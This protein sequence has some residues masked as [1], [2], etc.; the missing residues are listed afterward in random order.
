MRQLIEQVRA[1]FESNFTVAGLKL[2]IILW[3][4]F[5]IIMALIVDSP[6]LLAG[7]LAYEVLP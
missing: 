6:W 7:M 2:L 4:I 5:V 3:A 1:Y